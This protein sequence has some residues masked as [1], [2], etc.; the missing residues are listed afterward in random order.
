[1]SKSK[2]KEEM[3]WYKFPLNDIQDF[4]AVYQNGINKDDYFKNYA[5]E[6]RNNPSIIYQVEA[7]TV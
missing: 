7:A 3:S 6:E 1:M 2:V 5:T 4:L